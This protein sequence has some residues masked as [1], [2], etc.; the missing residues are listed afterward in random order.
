M[1]E[2]KFGNN[3]ENSIAYIS[4]R[5]AQAIEGRGNFTKEQI[6]D[7][8]DITTNIAINVVI[9]HEKM[10]LNRMNEMLEDNPNPET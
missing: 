8:I 6:K 5:T 7:I 9:G 3:L 10:L 1:N 2:N 4:M